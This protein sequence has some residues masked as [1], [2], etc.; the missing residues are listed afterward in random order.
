MID[1]I[2]QLKNDFFAEKKYTRH[3]CHKYIDKI[4]HLKAQNIDD[5][6]DLKTL[7]IIQDIINHKLDKIRTIRDNIVSIVTSIFLPLSFIVGFFGMNFKSLGA[8][9]LKTGIYSFNHG[10]LFIFGLILL[11]V[12]ITL[13]VLYL[14][15]YNISV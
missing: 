1:P 15:Q 2:I 12:V 13:F 9:T 5:K 4:Y 14:L 11:T 7:E 8:P 6:K 10:Y 3:I